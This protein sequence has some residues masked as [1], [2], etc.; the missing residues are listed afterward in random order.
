MTDKRLT[1]TYLF[2]IL[3]LWIMGFSSPLFAQDAVPQKEKLL[4]QYEKVLS[5]AQELNVYG[6]DTFHVLPKIRQI[7]KALLAEHY[8]EAENLLEDVSTNLELLKSKTPQVMDRSLKLEWLEIYLDLFQKYALLALFAFAWMR[9]RS[10]KSALSKKKLS[11]PTILTMSMTSAVLGIVLSLFDLSRYGESAWAFFDIQVVLTVI[12]GLL[13]GAVPGLLTAGCFASFRLF[14]QP[15]ALV[16]AVVIGAAS[17]SGIFSGFLLKDFRKSGW[18]SFLA[19]FSA[20][21]LHAGMIYAQAFSWMPFLSW[22]ASV[23]FIGLLEGVGVWIFFQVISGV[24][25][26]EDQKETEQSLLKTRLLFLQAQMN[27]HFVFNALNTISVICERDAGKAQALV[28]KLS[29]FLRRTLKREEETVSLR[30]EMAYIDAYLELERAR[31]QNRLTV[32]KDIQ[33]QDKTWEMSLPLLILQPLVENA[34]KYGAGSRE[35]GGTVRIKIGE[36]NSFLTV[37]IL[38]NGSGLSPVRVEQILQ[39]KAHSKNGAGIGLKNIHERLQRLYGPSF[40]LRFEISEWGGALVRVRI[41][42]NGD[43]L[44]QLVPIGSV[45]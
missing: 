31:F 14:F 19:G 22:S 4:G 24:L 23:L 34:V 26:E 36:E 10:M 44:Q 16:Y 33:I 8:G 12:A 41:P 27:P 13:G 15:H 32:D 25:R 30:E 5:L 17:L 29:E 18:I 40:G 39:G 42:T 7:S 28:L 43:R 1:M 11:L 2:Y 3:L 45:R 38:D 21:L 37:E 9:W 6:Q 20:G 35:S